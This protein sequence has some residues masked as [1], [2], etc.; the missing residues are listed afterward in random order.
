MAD[1]A[2]HILHVLPLAGPL[3]WVLVLVVLEFKEW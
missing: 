1:L 2:M 3:F